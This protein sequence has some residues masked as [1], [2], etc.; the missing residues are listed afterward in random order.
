MLSVWFLREFEIAEVSE[1]N[2]GIQRIEPGTAAFYLTASARSM[3]S[4][5]RIAT[6]RP[7]SDPNAFC[8]EK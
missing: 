7:P 6:H 8:G 3:A 1:R 5:E 2:G 4:G